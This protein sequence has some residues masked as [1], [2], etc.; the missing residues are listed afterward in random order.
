[1]RVSN[2]HNQNRSWYDHFPLRDKT[3]LTTSNSEITLYPMEVVF[4]DDDLDR[5]ETDPSYNAGLAEG[6]VR[7]Y[8]MR[9]Q[10]IRSAVDER[11]LRQMK[12]HRFEKLKGK[13]AHQHSLRL[14]DR[15]RLIVEIIESENRKQVQIVSIEDYH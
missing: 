4:A 9:V 7:A 8:R 6:I 11:D 13:R 1:M 12:S 10:S 14:N 5:L 3:E 15:F 2:A